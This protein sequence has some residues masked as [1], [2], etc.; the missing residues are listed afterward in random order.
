MAN[1]SPFLIYFIG[2]MFIPLFKGW[3][4]KA[5]LLFISA[6]AAINIALMTPQTSWIIKFLNLKITLLEADKLSLFVGYIFILIGV[7]N[8]IYVL[9]VEDSTHHMLAFLYVGSSL[10]VVFSG[11]YLSLYV[12]WEI[13]A[14]SST[15]LIWLNKERESIDAGFRYLFM[16]LLGGAFLP[17]FWKAAIAR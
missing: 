10:G 4:K 13:M 14:L 11:D 15:G 1:V 9:H 6:I 8:V 3:L 16:H 12:F 2:A 5:Y 7:I 17:F